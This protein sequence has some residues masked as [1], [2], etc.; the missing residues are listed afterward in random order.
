MEQLFD[1]S[2]EPLDFDFVGDLIGPF[3]S[4]PLPVD[5]RNYSVGPALRLQV[6][7]TLMC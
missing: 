6:G 3:V 1:N 5:L 4:Y 2:V 7:S